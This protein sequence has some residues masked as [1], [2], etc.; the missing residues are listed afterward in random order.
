MDPLLALP[1]SVTLKIHLQPT[2]VFREM[3]PVLGAPCVLGAP[4]SMLT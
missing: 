1:G 2:T 3:E 4:K